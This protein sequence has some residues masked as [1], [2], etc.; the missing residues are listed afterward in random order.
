M[1]MNSVSSSTGKHIIRWSEGLRDA[2]RFDI[3]NSDQRGESDNHN[4]R[5]EAVMQHLLSTSSLHNV[6]CWMW[7]NCCSRQ[8]DLP[9]S[10]TVSASVSEDFMALYKYCYYYK[11]CRMFWMQADQLVSSHI[12]Y[13]LSLAAAAKCPMEKLTYVSV[14]F[15]MLLVGLVAGNKIS[16]QQP[17][18]FCLQDYGDCPTVSLLLLITFYGLELFFVFLGHVSFNFA[19]CAG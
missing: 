3:D 2:Q 4:V 19:L 1:L 14:N 13:S 17:Q 5:V 18:W 11:R 15:L 12:P 8:C 10:R 7:G 16:F 9:R 6:L